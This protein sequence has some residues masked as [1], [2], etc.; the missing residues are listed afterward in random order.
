M[1]IY[2]KFWGTRG[3]IPT[4]GDRTR[5]YGGNTSCVEIRC[6]DHLFICDAGSG[7]REL[8][9]DLLARGKSPI[10][11]HLLFSHAHWD[12]I[13]GFPFFGP[14]DVPGNRF[15]IYGAKQGDDRFFELLSGQMKSDYFPIGFGALRAEISADHFDEGRKEI[16]GVL[17]QS[18]PLN[19]PGGCLGYAFL[20]E[21]KKIVYATDNEIVMETSPPD[22]NGRARLRFVPPALVEFVRGADLLIADGQYTDAEYKSRVGWGHTSCLTAVDCAVQ[23]GVKQLAVF[24]HDPAHADSFVDE[25]IESCRSRI[26]DLGAKLVVFAAREGVELEI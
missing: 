8:G 25:I 7:I 2:V 13:Q 26:S 17:V 18:F 22:S 19:H 6:G 3:S 20:H 21:S 16:G 10:S 14:A 12:H 11:G 9:A 5:K 4:P 1:E 24:H 15:L 23:A